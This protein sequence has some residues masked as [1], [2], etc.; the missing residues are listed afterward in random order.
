M[1]QKT[2]QQR[3]LYKEFGPGSGP[4]GILFYAGNEADITDFCKSAKALEYYGMRSNLA[5]I[6]IEHRYY[7]ESIPDN[8]DTGTVLVTKENA[9]DFM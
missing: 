9:A 6:F 1:P 5:V 4:I 2:F 8:I 7:G 3:Y